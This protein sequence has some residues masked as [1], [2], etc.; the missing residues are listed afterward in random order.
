DVADATDVFV[1]RD[2]REA[3]RPARHP[4]ES[5]SAR[6]HRPKTI[7]ADDEISS[8]G[9][10]L[11]GVR[12]QLRAAYHTVVDAEARRTNTLAHVDADGA[13]A[14]EQH[15]VENFAPDGQP[16]IAEWCVGMVGDELAAD[17]FSVRRADD[18]AA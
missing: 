14:I 16:A 17:L 10:C 15:P 13:R 18:D 2:E 8:D 9:E 1:V 5:K 4:R 7:G 11:I 12:Q 3:P 6:H